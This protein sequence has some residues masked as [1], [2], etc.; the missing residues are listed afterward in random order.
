MIERNQRDDATLSNL[1]LHVISL[2]A[3]PTRVRLS[4]QVGKEA[5]TR[6]RDG[7]AAAGMRWV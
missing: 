6:K 5:A 1:Y 4:N 2:V 3:L 7:S